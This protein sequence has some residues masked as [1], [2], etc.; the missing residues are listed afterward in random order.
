MHLR[1][2]TFLIVIFWLVMMGLLVKKVYFDSQ[3]LSLKTN[4]QALTHSIDT[5][6]EEE[7][8]GIYA[9]KNKIGYSVSTVQ[10]EE[11]TYVVSERTVMKLMVMGTPQRID[12]SSK[13]ILDTDFSLKSFIFSLQSGVVRLQTEA[14]IFK[15]EMKLKIDSGGRK[16]QRKI[17][18]QTPLYHQSSL[19]F[20][21]QEKGL[22]VGK[23]FSIP[24]FDPSTM[25]SGTVTITIEGKEN[26]DF[27]N[28]RVLTY[29]LKESFK[30]VLV[31]AWISDKGKILKEESPM[32]MV[33]VSETRE[34]ALNDNWSGDPG[35]DIIAWTAVPVDKPI[36]RPRFAK[37]LKVRLN[38]IALNDFNFIRHRQTLKEEVL[39]I[40]KEEINPIQS[41]LLPIEKKGYERY[42]ESSPFI[43]SNDQLIIEVA[44][45]IVHSEKDPLNMVKAITQWVYET[46]EKKPTM[47]IPS[48]LEVIKTKVGDCNEHTTLFTALARAKGI[49]TRIITGIVFFERNFFYHTWAEVFLGQWISVDPTMNQFPADATHIGFVEGELDKQMEI[50]KIIGNLKAEILEYK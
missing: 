42:L 37:Y 36:E 31:K 27:G 26:I 43:Q 9:G 50:M 35:I 45:K 10:K 32:G 48:A 18:L 21:M 11:N 30:G 6:S 20:L 44:N 4:V 47:S 25:S 22:A 24:V 1:T 16:I 40:T 28:E 5:T 3:E 8:M 7:W 15:D 12:T 49:P 23:T 33:M 34:K 14:E 13:S 39:E 17:S 38:G 41:T 46:I 19:R 2:L 29:R